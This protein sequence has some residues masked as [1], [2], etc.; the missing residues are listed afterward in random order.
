MSWQALRGIKVK[1]IIR[2]HRS[3]VGQIFEERFEITNPGKLPRVWIEVRDESPLP[4]AKGSRVFSWIKGSENRTYLVR[5]RLVERG[6]YQLGPTVLAAGDLFGLFP[7]NKK[8]PAENSILV[9]PMMVNIDAFPN[10]AGWL[11]GGEA[12]QRRTHQI[13]TNAAGVREYTPGDPMNRIHWLSTARR[14]RFIVKEFELDPLAE[15]WIFLDAYKYVQASLPYEIPQF[16]AR[17]QWRPAVQ[18]PLKPA[19]LEYSVT[20]AASLARYFLRHNRAVGFVSA[21]RSLKMLP[22]DRGLRQL[23]KI[24]EALAILGGDGNLPIEGVVES[25]SKNIPRGSTVII[26]SPAAGK[27]IPLAIE[28]LTLRGFKPIVIYIDGSSFGNTGI[29]R[30]VYTV[31]ASLRIPYCSISNGDDLSARLSSCFKSS[32]PVK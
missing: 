1:R 14:N 17:D 21:S 22:S 6:V 26:I 24:L 32:M 25:Q 27:G 4:G 31:L 7:V 9:Y 30:G 28:E 12:I 3:Q 15:V 5:T 18:V 13:T 8:Y 20:I 16:E 11:P 23:G 19:S 29:D 10:P 2:T